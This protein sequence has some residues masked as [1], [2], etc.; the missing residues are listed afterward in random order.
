M[1]IPP[2]DHNSVIPPFTTTPTNRNDLSP[3]HVTI[4]EV[5]QRFA[6]TNRRK[7][8]LTGFL[9]MRHE[10]RSL[11]I[12]N[13]F[14][15]LN[16]SFCTDVERLFGVDPDDIDVVTFFKGFSIPQLF[17]LVKR[18]DLFNNR[19]SKTTYHVDHFPVPVDRDGM[20]VVEMTRYWTQLFSHTKHS[21]IWKGMLKV[22][23]NTPSED[24]EARKYL[25]LQ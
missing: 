22:D 3:Y 11:G 17:D 9:D 24:V 15:W 13:G 14:Q 10:L 18:A 2:F 12:T 7:V 8:I 21:Y 16:G 20:I 25:I 23:L 1:P 5:C 4:G 19:E 6:T